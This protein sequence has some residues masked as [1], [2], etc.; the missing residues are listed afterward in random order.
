MISEAKRFPPPPGIPNGCLDRQTNP[1]Q[2]PL[3]SPVFE[4]DVPQ[5]VIRR[6]RWP[7]VIP[8]MNSTAYHSTQVKDQNGEG[9]C[10]S[11]MTASGLQNIL[12]RQGFA[13]EN[14]QGKLVTDVHLSPVSL[15]KRVNGGRDSG[16]SIDTNLEEI[17]RNGI[18]PEKGQGFAHEFP[19]V[20]WRT[21][22]PD[23][24]EETAKLF[25]F[26]EWWDIQT[27]EGFVSALLL[28]VPVA[29]GRSGHAILAVSARLDSRGRL[30]VIYQNSWGNW[31]GA[32]ANHTYGFGEDD[33]SDFSSWIGRYGAWAPRVALTAE[34]T[35]GTVVPNRSGDPLTPKGPVPW[36]PK[37]AA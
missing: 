20:G 26:S 27:V 6:D 8:K 34:G 5:L 9:S 11:N 21:R 17:A 30:I 10:A 35:V 1:G 19:A 29:Y 36:K 16:S 4:D 7:E 12:T 28:G 22:L 33:E 15:Y 23:G 32:N 14:A 3:G 37:G 2:D 24:W 13:V 31:G 25:R 18:L